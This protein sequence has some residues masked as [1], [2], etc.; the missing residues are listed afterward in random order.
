MSFLVVHGVVEYIDIDCRSALE[1]VRSTLTA[2]VE[3][4]LPSLHGT[5]IDWLG[6]KQRLIA[7]ELSRCGS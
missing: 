6:G 4:V 3:D 1:Q 5:N 2:A 7:R